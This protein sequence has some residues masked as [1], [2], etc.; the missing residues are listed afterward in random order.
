MLATSLG[1]LLA[2]IPAAP[3]TPPHDPSAGFRRRAPYVQVSPG[4]LAFDVTYPPL[5]YYAWGVEAGISSPFRRTGLLTLG[6]FFE[7]LFYRDQPRFRDDE[8][9]PDH[10]LLRAGPELRVGASNRRVFGYGLLRAGLDLYVDPRPHGQI[11]PLFLASIGPGMQA[12]FAERFILGAE[13]AM[14]LHVQRDGV[15]WLFRARILLGVL[16]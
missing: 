14:D 11:S 16:F 6:G 8:G 2:A 3:P 12:M 1:V 15:G 13:P 7:H 5:R 9:I 10:H 4:I